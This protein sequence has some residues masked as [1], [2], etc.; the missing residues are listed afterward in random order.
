MTKQFI[1]HLPNTEGTTATFKDTAVVAALLR[2]PHKLS[3]ATITSDGLCF[4]CRLEY[5]MEEPDED[6]T[7][8]MRTFEF[9]FSHSSTLLSKFQDLILDLTEKKIPITFTID[10]RYLSKFKL[11]PRSQIYYPPPVVKSKASKR[12]MPS[13]RNK[14][15]DD[16]IPF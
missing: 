16:D 6:D 10:L 8:L 2:D 15:D 5:R 1:R 7:P 4:V 14:S 9:E 13:K 11:R 12:K 3:A